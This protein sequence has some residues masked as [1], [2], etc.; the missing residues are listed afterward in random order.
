M[1]RTATAKSETPA[2]P[3]VQVKSEPKLVTVAC[4][5][6]QGVRLQLCRRVDFVED[7]PSG[8]RQKFRYDKFGDVVLVRGPAIPRSYDAKF[9]MPEIVGGAA[10]T[11]N[12]DGDFWREWLKQHADSDLVKGKMIFAYDQN[13]DH[14]QKRAIEQ[15]DIRSGLEPV[16]PNLKTDPRVPKSIVSG[17]SE[18]MVADEM[19]SS[20]RRPAP[21]PKNMPDEARRIDDANKEWD[22]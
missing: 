22:D 7:T 10:L 1:A 6:P 13:T 18:I 8:P 20:I 16:D 3:A 14:V 12:V 19:S 9:P 2:A 15:K 5:I 4:K 17:V 21:Q 11:R